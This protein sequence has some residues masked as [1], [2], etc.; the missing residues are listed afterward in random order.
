MSS[1]KTTPLI[2][3]EGQTEHKLLVDPDE[4]DNKQGRRNYLGLLFAFLAC[5]FFFLV[6]A[7][8]KYTY[9]LY[10]F[11]TPMDV[12]VGHAVVPLFCSIQAAIAR[13]NMFVVVRGIRLT[14]FFRVV[15]MT[16]ALVFYFWGVELLTAS[17][18]IVLYNLVPFF[19]SFFAWCYLRER[20]HYADGI[21]LAVSF[22]GVFLIAYFAEDEAHKDTQ[23]LGVLVM[24]AAAALFGISM[25]L[26]RA[27]GS[28]VHYLTI[29]FYLGL[30]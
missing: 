1:D 17:K 27:A 5:V 9:L 25:T 15:T 28:H 3:H 10:P 19:V 18:A 16:A 20:L 7:T 8:I 4:E 12:M 24:L 6:V 11:L 22:A 14:V 30:F 21:S 29:P 13:K 2:D 26:H 23:T